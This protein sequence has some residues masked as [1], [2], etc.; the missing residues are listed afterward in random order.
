[1]C[2]RRPAPSPADT[3]DFRL[4]PTWSGQPSQDPRAHTTGAAGSALTSIR[5]AGRRR[6]TPGGQPFLEALRKAR[7]WTGRVVSRL[8]SVFAED[9]W[10]DRRVETLVCG[11]LAL[12]G[13]PKTPP[14]GVISHT[15][16]MRVS[17]IP[18]R[19]EAQ[20]CSRQGSRGIPPGPRRRRWPR[21]CGWLGCRV[22]G[23][24][25]RGS[26][27]LSGRHRRGIDLDA[28][29]VPRDGVGQI[30]DSIEHGVVDV[31]VA[32]QQTVQSDRLALGE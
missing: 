10:P 18:R 30:E 29:M 8:R 26:D 27:T 25:N 3:T 28:E 24:R 22:R 21:E 7:S 14:D 2:R 17:A 1:M 12:L 5:R 11:R 15:A 19:G 6:T 16:V 31:E 23:L 32:G 4:P 20:G 9:V 13:W